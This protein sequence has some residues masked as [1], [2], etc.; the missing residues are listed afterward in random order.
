MARGEHALEALKLSKLAL[1][2]F[3]TFQLFAQSPRQPLI[4]CPDVGPPGSLP[5]GCRPV[6]AI[7]EPKVKHIDRPPSGIPPG[8]SNAW[9]AGYAAAQSAQ[10]TRIMHEFETAALTPTPAC[11][12]DLWAAAIANTG[13]RS[14]QLQ[15]EVQT[16]APTSEEHKKRHH[17]PFAALF[18]KGA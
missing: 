10:Y 13:H 4:E 18:G 16:V 9:N 8:H 14:D 3:A 6:P 17:N 12:T 2:V 7:V 15:S 5:A 11:R 1:L